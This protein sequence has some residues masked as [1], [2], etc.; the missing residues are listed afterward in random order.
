MYKHF[1]HHFSPTRKASNPKGHSPAIAYHF[2]NPLTTL[3]N[4][5]FTSSTSSAINF[6]GPWPW[7]HT[8]IYHLSPLLINLPHPPSNLHVLAHSNIKHDTS[9]TCVPCLLDTPSLLSPFGLPPQ[10]FPP[11]GMIYTYDIEQ[12]R[13]NKWS[14]AA[15]SPKYIHLYIC[16]STFKL[17][18]MNKTWSV[19]ASLFWQVIHSYPGALWHAHILHSNATTLSIFSPCKS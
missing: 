11:F 9:S 14:G 3:A 12:G 7:P 8:R 19:L 16:N 15:I 18:A 10:R 5:H 6:P 2:C 1:A 17:F 4:P 13:T